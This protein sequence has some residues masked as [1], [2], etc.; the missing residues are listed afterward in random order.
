MSFLD[1]A[2]R[3]GAYTLPYRVLI[4]RRLLRR[5]PVG[6][7]AARLDAGAVHRPNY[8][9][10]VY[11]AAL[12]AVALGHKAMTVIEFGVAGG[13][14]LLN[15]CGH[16]EEIRRALGIEIVV[17]GFDSG[18]GLPATRDSRDLLYFWPSGSFEMDRGAL[19]KRLQGRAELV[20]GNVADTVHSWQ[21]RADAPVGAIL[22]DLDFYTSTMAAFGIFSQQN[23][24]P[25]VW[26]YFDDICG[27]PGNAMTDYLGEREAVKQFN[28]DPQ[29]IVMRD[30]LSPARAFKGLTPE[31][32]H[33]Q[34]YLY[35]R[36]SHP[37]YDT[38]LSRE[39]KQQLPLR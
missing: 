11:H 39:A 28:L 29:R 3:A 38:C 37:A 35:H 33:E 31:H 8:G 23:I 34:I 12:E 30:H 9:W 6:S 4:L 24:L 5:W 16:G 32:W 14:G 20:L 7:Y 19:E 10:C 13:N 36:M 25:R 22:F 18:A 15:L 21:P 26:C 1:K 17:V 27:Y 2:I